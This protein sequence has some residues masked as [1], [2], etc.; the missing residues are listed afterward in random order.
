MDMITALATI[1][2]ISVM[3]YLVVYAEC[4]APNTTRREQHG[5]R[6]TVSQDIS[7]PLGAAN[8][9]AYFLRN[10][11]GTHTQLNWWCL[12]DLGD[13]GIFS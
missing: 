7:H 12:K 13:I 3:F 11:E 2:I 4:L 10:Q 1:S 5:Q 8:S 6:Y 9:T